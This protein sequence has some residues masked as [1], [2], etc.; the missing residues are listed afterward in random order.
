M[1][2][3]PERLTITASQW[4]DLLQSEYLDGYIQG[5]GSAIKVVS[6]SPESL[7]E[8]KG[9]ARAAASVAD[10]FFADLDPAAPD[11]NNKRP[12]LHRIDRFF[13]AAT[14][15]V[16]WK[17]WAADQA[18]KHFADH[19]VH[20]A[21]GRALSDL[22][23]IAQDNGREASDLLSEY[24]RGVATEQIRDR[25]MAVEFR[26]AVTALG[27]AQILPDSITPTTEEVLLA[28]FSGRANQRALPG[29]LA[30]L[31]RL[32]IQERINQ[33]N[34]RNTLA[35]FCRWLPRAGH[36]G[37]VVLLDLRPYE[38]KKR[39]KLQRERDELQKYRDLAAR[40]A[41]AQEMTAAAAEAQNAAAEPVFTYSDP[42]YI[43]MLTLVRHFIDEIDAFE[44]F[45]LVVLTSPA[46]YAP[47]ERATD[48]RYIDYDAL[49]T[50]IGLEVHDARRANPSAA[51]VHLGEPE[52]EF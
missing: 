13:F 21:P 48:R 5:G 18:R 10:C 34:A 36:S 1:E 42:A 24:Q 47:R 37:M 7:A 17:G 15:A 38:Y 40:G 6:G 50:R 31:K 27:R 25:G 28:W 23:G 51:L 52:R 9:R 19:G 45:L 8:V 22:E 12:E 41:S 4:A 26:T 11:E 3:Q 35:S 43:Q 46:F 44:R 2:T 29:A 14:R 32:Q 39:S 16:N 49:Q 30:A 20:V 33:A